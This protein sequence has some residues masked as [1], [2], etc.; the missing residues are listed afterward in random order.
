MP[1]SVSRAS[2]RLEG[3][4]SCLE[5]GIQFA[6]AG[7]RSRSRR[8]FNSAR[9][10]GSKNSNKTQHT[11]LNA[12]GS[13]DPVGRKR[14]ARNTTSAPRRASLL[15]H[16]QG[17][18]I[19]GT[20]LVLICPLQ[21]QLPPSPRKEAACAAIHDK[22]DIVPLAAPS[23]PPWASTWAGHH[24]RWTLRWTVEC[25]DL[26]ATPAQ[27]LGSSH[28]P[29]CND[30]SLSSPLG[31]PLHETRRS[32]HPPPPSLPHLTFSAEVK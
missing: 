14:N 9:L 5:I 31:P 22:K 15:Q 3:R 19:A 12:Q 27:T 30:V 21:L 32:F 26:D 24:R 16:W 17:V 11:H 28:E 6:V 29:C 1:R 18:G 2:F 23:L 4:R 25:S 20:F 10:S 8:R 13:P 7:F